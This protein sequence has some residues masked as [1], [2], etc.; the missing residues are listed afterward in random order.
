MPKR[1]NF[2]IRPVKSKEEVYREVKRKLAHTES[3]DKNKQ[4]SSIIDDT[5]KDKSK[6]PGNNN[7]VDSHISLNCGKPLEIQNSI[8]FLMRIIKY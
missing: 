7:T 4:K 6:L 2:S 1:I 3:F 5:H 8:H